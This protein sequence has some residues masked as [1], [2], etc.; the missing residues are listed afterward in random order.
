MGR[1]PRLTDYDRELW[2]LQ[3]LPV[4]TRD[5]Y[6]TEI[7]LENGEQYERIRVHL[8]RVHGIVAIPRALND[9]FILDMWSD[10]AHNDAGFDLIRESERCVPDEYGRIGDV[11][12]YTLDE[13]DRAQEAAREI[14]DAAAD[15]IQW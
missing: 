2:A 10:A 12:V 1:T 5:L 3:A 8:R 6:G 9:E 4:G 15:D 14:A 11:V 7:L 13:W